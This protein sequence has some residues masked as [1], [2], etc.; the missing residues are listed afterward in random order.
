MTGA[1]LFTRRFGECPLVAILRGVRP[2]EVEGI[3]AALIGAGVRIIEVPLNSPDPLGSIAR[4]A[5][6]F[7]EEALIGAGTVL[8]PADVPRVADAGGQL[9]VSPGT[10]PQVIAATVEAGLVSA[11]G[12]FT[13]S[14]AFAAI[15][16][17]AHALKLFPAEAAPPAVLKAQAAVL[18]KHLPLIVVGGITPDKM[19]AYRAAGAHGF[20]LGGALYQPGM[21]PDEVAARARDFVAA[22]Q[23]GAA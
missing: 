18:P 23:E 16:A 13:P 15:R 7:G 21:T 20:G 8:D 9:I 19:A 6:R 1:A 3:G 11:P 12:Y 22:L 17:G 5:R 4:L 14:E 2:G 10:D